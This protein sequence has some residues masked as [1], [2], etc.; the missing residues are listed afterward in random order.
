[1]SNPEKTWGKATTAAFELADLSQIPA[2]TLLLTVTGDE[3]HIVRD[4]DAKRIFNESTHVPLANKDYVTLVSDDHGLPALKANH[5][6]P[7]AWA[8]LPDGSPTGNSKSSGPLRELFRQKLEERRAEDDEMPDFSQ[9][10]R[11]LDALDYFGLWKLFDGLTDAAFFGTNRNYALGN[12]PEQ[13]FMGV[14]SDGRP[15]KELIV[16]K[17]P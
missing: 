11:S 5:M 4:I 7:V 10:G 12:T 1:V 8:P 16:T 17:H 3:D 2:E 15:V 14:W 9:T 13:R 6:A